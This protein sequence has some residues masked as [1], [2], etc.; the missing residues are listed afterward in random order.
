VERPPVEAA[1]L[2]DVEMWGIFQFGFHLADELPDLLKGQRCQKALYRV[3]GAL[4]VLRDSLPTIVHSCTA[5]IV[6]ISVALPACCR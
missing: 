1:L 2:D 3:A 5:W 4:K 6:A